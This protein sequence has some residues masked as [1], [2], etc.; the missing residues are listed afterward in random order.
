MT[1]ISLRAYS[2]HRGVTLRAVQKAIESGRIET[3]E[4]EKGRKRINPEDADLRWDVL[5]DP[6]KQR[7]KPPGVAP[8]HEVIDDSV[9]EGDTIDDIPPD[10][11]TLNDCPDPDDPKDAREKRHDYF[12]ARAMREAYQ[13]ELSKLNYQQRSG[14]LVEVAKVRSEIF[15]L[16]RKTRDA[17][18]NVPNRI[19][20]QLASETDPTKVH[21]LLN[22][23]L[24]R[25]LEELID[26]GRRT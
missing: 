14:E 16:T 5:T 23:A 24:V 11:V 12:K 22:E 21:N 3:V 13:A 26:A 2:R 1:L 6:A 25:A 20:S 4:D 7:E 19:A 15:D 8:V 10:E 17:I 18:L 9:M